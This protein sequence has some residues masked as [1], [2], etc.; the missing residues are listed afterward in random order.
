MR[1]AVEEGNEAN[2]LKPEEQDFLH[3]RSIDL[4]KSGQEKE[5]VRDYY[6]GDDKSCSIIRISKR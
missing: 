2:E 4:P 6:P 1:R 3:I 5:V